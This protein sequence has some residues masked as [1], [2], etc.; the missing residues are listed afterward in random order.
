MTPAPPHHLT[1]SRPLQETRLMLAAGSFLR[2]SKARVRHFARELKSQLRLLAGIEDPWR[3]FRQLASSVHPGTLA[4]REEI[5]R[6]LDSLPAACKDT[7]EPSGTMA[8]RGRE[9]RE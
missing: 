3:L 6:W 4:C 2:A 8:Q 9:L 1:T 5:G 7:S